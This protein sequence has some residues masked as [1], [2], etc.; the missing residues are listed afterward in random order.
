[1]LE[2]GVFREGW[3]T[4]IEGCIYWISCICRDGYGI[5]IK[6]GIYWSWALFEKIRG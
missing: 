5:K 4:V 3:G 1:V 2:S 6:G